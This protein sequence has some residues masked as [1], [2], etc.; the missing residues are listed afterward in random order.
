MINIMLVDDHALFRECLKS[1]IESNDSY[2]IICEAENGNEC[3]DKLRL[4][5]VD[6]ILLDINMPGKNGIETME[7]INRKRIPV[8]VIILTMHNELK[9]LA[10]CIELG[11]NG[12]LLKEVRLSELME[13]I[14]AVSNGEVFIQSNLIP[15]Y[16]KYLI[17]QDDDKNMISNLTPRE[18]ELLKTIARGK[19]NRDIAFEFNIS[20][21]TVKNHISHIFKKINVEDRTQAAVFAIKN[22]LIK[23]K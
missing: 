23:I 7:F 2:K 13:A 16:N 14:E 8:K 11:V 3:I 10:E 19:S 9:H 20:E 6:I 1:S 12:Y 15:M 5:P 18:L 21:R 17:T 22:D 4:Y